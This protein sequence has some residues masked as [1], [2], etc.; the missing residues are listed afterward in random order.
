MGHSLQGLICN[1]SLQ[2]DG[3]KPIRN[4]LDDPRRSGPALDIDRKEGSRRH[5]RN[6]GGLDFEKVKT[7]AELERE[8]TV[9]HSFLSPPGIERR[10]L[11]CFRAASALF[12]HS[13]SEAGPERRLHGHDDVD[14]RPRESRVPSLE[15]G[16]RAD[17]RG[18]ISAP[19][20]RH[21]PVETGV[22]RSE[23]R[24]HVSWRRNG[25]TLRIKDLELC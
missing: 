2:P 16:A 14:D 19:P 17:R 7:G 15:E 20:Q 5:V 12:V 21:G 4:F 22:G 9:S 11:W 8:W 3:D 23:D 10:A 25:L 18:E 1:L 13:E 6:W 24:E